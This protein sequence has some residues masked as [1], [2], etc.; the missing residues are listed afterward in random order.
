MRNVAFL[1]LL[2]STSSSHS[3][4]LLCDE[5]MCATG[6]S[7]ESF[8]SVPVDQSTAPLRIL[9]R[10]SSLPEGVDVL[11]SVCLSSNK[12]AL[13]CTASIY[14]MPLTILTRFDPYRRSATAARQSISAQ[15]QP[16]PR[17]C[18]RAVA[19]NVAGR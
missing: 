13:D 18:T 16:W 2:P 14:I 9:R 1:L 19:G 6:C 17:K 8:R 7:A 5:Q 4:K 3:S 11:Q 12:A 15:S 10:R